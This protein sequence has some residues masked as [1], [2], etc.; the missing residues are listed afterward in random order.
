MSKIYC[1]IEH[2]NRQKKSTA[3]ANDAGVVSV[4][5]WHYQL[6]AMLVDHGGGAEDKICVTL[7]EIETGRFFVLTHGVVGEILKAAKEQEERE[8]R[9]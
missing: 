1:T 6:E 5:N 8:C 9:S 7:R 3:R 4:K 2:S